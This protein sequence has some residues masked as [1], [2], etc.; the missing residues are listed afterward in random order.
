MFESVQLTIIDYVALAFLA[1]GLIRGLIRGLAGELARLAGVA[2]AVLAGWHLYEPIGNKISE[3][4]RLT[5]QD[6]YLAGFVLTAGA[7]ALIMLLARWSMK[8]LMEL[9]FNPVLNRVGGA[10]AGLLRASLLLSALFI[11]MSL[12]RVDYLR[13][14]FTEE[15]VVGSTIKQHVMPVYESLTEDKP[16]LRFEVEPPTDSKTQNH[17]NATESVE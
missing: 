4:T 17:D 6:S 3:F 7:V 1:Y 12:C 15:S 10:L 9:A 5:G 14:K 16:E 13:T 11:G 8:Q 2:L